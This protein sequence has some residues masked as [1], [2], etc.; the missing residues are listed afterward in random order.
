ML[1]THTAGVPNARF[2]EKSKILSHALS[3]LTEEKKHRVVEELRHSLETTLPV[4]LVH[5]RASDGPWARFLA[6]G[7]RHGLGRAQGGSGRPGAPRE[8][9]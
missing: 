4:R 8:Q 5:E 7:L 2:R 1:L 3:M 6:V 9:R